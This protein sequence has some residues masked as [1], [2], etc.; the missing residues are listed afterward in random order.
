VKHPATYISFV[1]GYSVQSDTEDLNFGKLYDKKEEI[2]RKF[3]RKFG[4]GFAVFHFLRNQACLRVE[5][6]RFRHICCH[7]L[8]YVICYM[9]KY[10]AINFAVRLGSL[11]VEPCLLYTYIFR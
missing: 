3:R 1:R 4:D 7:M 10:K 8:S 9:R 2:I 5:G 11:S 6:G